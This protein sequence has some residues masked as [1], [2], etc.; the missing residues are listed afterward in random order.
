MDRNVPHFK[1]K[2]KK[3]ICDV[4]CILQNETVSYVVPSGGII[5]F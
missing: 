5:V 4:N 2:L 1:L 3:K